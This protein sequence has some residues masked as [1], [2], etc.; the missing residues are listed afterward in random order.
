M[1]ILFQGKKKKP[2][3][4]VFQ[5]FFGYEFK[6][7]LYKKAFQYN[8]YHPLVDRNGRCAGDAAQGEVLSWGGCC[9]PREVLSITGRSII[10]PFSPVGRQT[11]VIYYLAPNFVNTCGVKKTYLYTFMT[12]EVWPCTSDWAVNNFITVVFG[13]NYLRISECSFCWLLHL[14]PMIH[15]YW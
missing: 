7:I 15:Y 10:T 9:C 5:F 4:I 1:S 12:L 14:L 2:L 3:V 6:P 8:A 13:F 11:L